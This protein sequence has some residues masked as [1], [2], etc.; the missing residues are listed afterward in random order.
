MAYSW[1][2]VLVTD[3]GPPAIID[4]GVRTHLARSDDNGATFTFERTI[5]ATQAIGHPDT[6]G[7]G[8]LIHEVPTMAKQADN[9]WQSLWLQY[10]DPLGDPPP[11]RGDFQYQRS[12]DASPDQL[13][14]NATAWARGP[15]T[16]AS[17]GAQL[18][19]SDIPELSDC[20]VHTEPALFTFGSD[21]YLATTCIVIVGVDRRPDL[22]RLV[23]LRQEAGGYAFVATLLD[24]DDAA[25]VNADVL[26]QADLSVARNGDVLLLVTPIVLDDDPQ[27]K[28]CRVFSFEDF[29]TGRLLRDGSGAP[30]PR[31]IITADGN[32]LGPGLCSY[33][34]DSNT[35]VLLVIT[36]VLGNPITDIEFS[37]R[38]TG[39]H[40]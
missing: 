21:I 22:E 33:D 7:L 32:G 35:G 15:A 26:E 23:L 36:T 20:T 34:A 1:L 11:E 8:W 39:V 24:A 14:V 38:A 6:G 18:N 2:D 31:A 12:I 13:G 25:G 28:G 19:L 29:A 17:F 40:P 10:F 27:H 37:L 16:S 4:F 3:P 30:I 9:Q 5:N